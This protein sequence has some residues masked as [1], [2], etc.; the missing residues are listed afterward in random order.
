MIPSKSGK[1]SAPNASFSIGQR[2]V[3]EME[4]ELGLGAILQIDHR[5]ITIAFHD[6][7]TVRI[8]TKEN[9][10]LRRIKF[11]AGDTIHTLNGDTCHIESTDEI[12][13]L[14]NYKTENGIICETQLSSVNKITA[15]MDRLLTSHVDSNE[16]FK[17]RKDI[18]R[19]RHRIA[20]SP[21]RGYV[22]GRIDL[23]PHQLYIANEVSSR[24]VRRVMLA[25]EVGLGKTIE[26]CL[27]L[28]R[29]LVSGRVSQVMIIVPE[30]MV[31]VWFVELLRKFNLIFTIV[32]S[33]VEDEVPVENPFVLS[34]LILIGMNEFVKS[35][36][37][38]GKAS[39]VNWDMVIVDEAH[40]L[41]KD[42]PAFEAIESISKS[43]KDLFF[44]T[45]TP[46]HFGEK[47]H[48]ARLQL[49]DPSRYSSFEEHCKE[50]EEHKKIATLTGKILDGVKL[51]EEDIYQL[52]TLLNSDT[53]L[54]MLKSDNSGIISGS[55]RKQIVAEI[56]DRQGIGR[57]LFRNTRTIIG[58][59]PKRTVTIQVFE[60]KKEQR[61]NVAAILK[62]DLQKINVQNKRRFTDDPRVTY[63]ADMLKKTEDDKVLVIC[64]SKFSVIALDEA[65]QKKIN[66]KTALFHED[67]TLLQRDRNAAYFSEDEGARILICSEIG[68]EGRNF[69]FAHNL[70]L[71]D[72]PANPELVE[73]RIGRLDRIGQKNTVDLFIPVLSDTPEEFLA[74]WYHEGLGIFSATVPAAQ[75]AYERFYDEIN[76]LLFSTDFANPKTSAAI[77]DLIE[78]TKAA[79]SEISLRLKIGRDRLLEQ[80]SFRPREAHELVSMIRKF[81]EDDSFKAIIKELLK[82]RGILPEE[83]Q[84]DTWNLL[85]ESQLD[86]SFP[87][88]SSSRSIVTFDRTKALQREDYE[89]LTIDHPAVTGGIDLFISSNTGNA[90]YAVKK[91]SNGA[92]LLME[93]VFVAECIAPLSLFID[94][95]LPPIVIRIVVNNKGIDRSDSV[96]HITEGSIENISTFPFMENIEVKQKLLPSML[97]RAETLAAEKCASLIK[98][99]MQKIK[100]IAGSE[101]ERLISLK[102]MNPS[103]SDQEIVFAE[104]EY[105]QL[106]QTVSKASPRLEAVRLI[107]CTDKT[108]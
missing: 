81:D 78:S 97:K 18:L 47:N 38:V 87:G 99:S 30:P 4:P 104:K 94:R 83:F 101:V 31:H 77:S 90:C 34:S 24:F 45:A 75:E 93:A 16:D 35:R 54:S 48:F 71:F 1:S 43:T 65:L 29:L 79:V 88:L 68:S 103:I 50:A 57:A 28:H 39:S 105:S 49:L 60:C 63:L 72:L 32:D 107:W 82:S 70:F 20:D 40:H 23:I 33:N 42:S 64:R 76:S 69:Q 62:E 8:Y 25:D 102:K 53:V 74:K 37:L 44:L 15:P 95:Y 84:S 67:L 11:K 2:W 108:I 52:Q 5:R 66:V 89:F 98:E 3:S 59:F 80:H 85:S 10:P 13:N 27:I 46:Q 96:A 92:E 14:M 17:L 86:E 6:G 56:L 58:G 51:V 100:S 55:D 21:V 106:M 61:T 41:V 7:E 12:N 36:E 91:V 9:A 73:Q 19:L 26:A 22:G